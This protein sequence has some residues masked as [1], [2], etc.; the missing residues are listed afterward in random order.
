MSEK[1]SSTDGFTKIF[2][3]MIL[4]D[5]ILYSKGNISLVGSNCAR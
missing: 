4:I 2:K 1:S 3:Q 5:V